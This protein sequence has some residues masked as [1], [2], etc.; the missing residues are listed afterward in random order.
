[1]SYSNPEVDALLFLDSDMVPPADMLLKLLEADKPIAGAL[2]FKRRP[3]YEPCIFKEV[4]ENSTEFYYDYPKG[5]IEI[6]GTGMACCLIKRCVL[7]MPKPWF[8]PSPLLGEDLAFCLR[9]RENGHSVW[10][11]T[12]LICGHA[13][14][15]V[16]DERYYDA[17]KPQLLPS[18]DASRQLPPGEALQGGAGC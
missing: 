4:T 14:T 17:Y 15:I 16:I 13:T 2:A 1:M 11:D 9:A 12:T 8:Y 6:A 10:C 18:S 3:P 7:D 5:L